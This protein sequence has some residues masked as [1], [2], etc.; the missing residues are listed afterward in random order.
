MIAI[1]LILLQFLTYQQKRL[2]SILIILKLWHPHLQ[3]QI[4]YRICALMASMFK[5]RTTRSRRWRRSTTSTMTRHSSGQTWRLLPPPHWCP[6]L[7]SQRQSHCSSDAGT[8]DA[9]KTFVENRMVF[10]NPHSTTIFS[11][12]K[13]KRSSIWLPQ[14]LDNSNRAQQKSPAAEKF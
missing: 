4:F 6:Q 14:V 5:Y 2:D 7:Q 12:L 13:E 10:I 1:Y 11:R 8:S 9:S 3:R